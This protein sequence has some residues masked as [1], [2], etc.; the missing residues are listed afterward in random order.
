MTH[1]ILLNKTIT[2]P[3]T[4]VVYGLTT[5]LA[6][7]KSMGLFFD[8][9]YGASGTN[10][11]AWIQTTFDNGATWVDIANFAATTASKRRMYNLSAL[12]AVSAIA[13]PTSGTLA[14]DTSVDGFIGDGLRLLLTTTGNYT[15][16][17]AYVHAV[18]KK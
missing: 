5:D 3:E 17:S 15:G 4:T 12:T 18:L 8:F 2:A 7:I 10:F 13:T 16:T 1:L 9:V 11:K 14:D 6:N